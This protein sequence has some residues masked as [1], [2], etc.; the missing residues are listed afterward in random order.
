MKK[1]I[2]RVLWA[3][4]IFAILLNLYHKDPAQPMEKSEIE[5]RDVDNRDSLAQIVIDNAGSGYVV[6]DQDYCRDVSRSGDTVFVWYSGGKIDTLIHP[7]DG[8]QNVFIGKDAGY[9]K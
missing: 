5:L 6:P 3:L 9:Q 8:R 7:R 4:L 1:W 2:L